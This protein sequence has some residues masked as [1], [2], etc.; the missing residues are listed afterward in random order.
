MLEK[1]FEKPRY[2]VAA[3]GALAAIWG[4]LFTIINFG[5]FAT[6][7]IAAI[8]GTIFKIIDFDL[9]AT[10]ASIFSQRTI[11]IA[12]TEVKALV[13]AAKTELVAL[14]NLCRSQ[15]ASDISMAMGFGAGHTQL[16]G[17]IVQ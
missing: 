1:V 14:R 15:G 17:R 8:W 10:I 4:T 16:I 13:A 2:I 6:I 3:I 12:A 11:A 9:F 7:A 5:L